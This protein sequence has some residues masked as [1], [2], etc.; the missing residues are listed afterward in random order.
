[1]QLFNQQQFDMAMICFDHSGDRNSASLAKAANLQK[2]GDS[3][4]T[5]NQ[6]IAFRHLKE[7]AEL[8]LTVGR[9][10]ASARCFIRV[11]EFQKAG[12]RSFPNRLI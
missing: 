5:D 6:E 3:C 1:V 2:I 12:N 11:G 8:F 7:A 10:E 9:A 4:F